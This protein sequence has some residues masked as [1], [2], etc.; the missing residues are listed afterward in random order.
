MKVRATF[1]TVRLEGRLLTAENI[2]SGDDK[3]QLELN[4]S[5]LT[6]D[7]IKLLKRNF[8]FYSKNEAYSYNID[9]DLLVGTYGRVN[10]TI[11]EVYADIN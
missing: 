8:D 5:L 2:R 3:V 7:E 1:I 11:E 10:I 9:A 6:E 4:P